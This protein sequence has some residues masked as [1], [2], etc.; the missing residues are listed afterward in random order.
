MKRYKKY[1]VGVLSAMVFGLSAGMASAT[2]M[3][4]ITYDYTQSG[5]SYF[6]DFTVKN[7][8]TEASTAGLDYFTINFDDDQVFSRYVSISW[9]NDN[10]W[11]S[12]VFQY[13][14]AFGENVVAGSVLADD[15]FFGSNG[16]G[17]AQG[18][19]EVFRVS[20]DYTGSIGADAHVFSW[21]ADFGTYET[22]V[23]PFYDVEGSSCGTVRYA[24]TGNPVPEPGTLLLVGTGLA[25]LIGATR[26]KFGK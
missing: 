4:D 26:R 17:L 25:G 10:G 9:V 7:T 20:F 15:S 8:S 2:Y 5:S 1:G 23:D 3:A 14:P 13:D 16:G 21:E 6:F 22:Q 18:S 12:S 24:D 19:S 11:D